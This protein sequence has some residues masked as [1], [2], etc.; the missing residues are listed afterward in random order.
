MA[1]SGMK[2]ISKSH[3]IKGDI[4]GKHKPELQRHII[5]EK[6]LKESNIDSI[7]TKDAALRNKIGTPKQAKLPDNK[8]MNG[9]ELFD[10][11]GD[12]V[13]DIIVQNEELYK[14]IKKL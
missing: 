12:N 6:P 14:N 9:N 2:N 1:E 7:D 4:K 13:K 10:N 5:N 8:F 11:S 3:S